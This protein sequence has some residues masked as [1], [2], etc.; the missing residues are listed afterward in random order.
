MAS[1]TD[2]RRGA[3]ISHNDN[4][5]LVLD[6]QHRTQGRQAGF[7]Q[8]T[9]RNLATGSSTNTKLRSGDSVD[10]LFTTRTSMEFSYIDG[11]DYHFL[12]PETFDDVVLDAKLLEEAKDFLEEGN[13]Y[14]ILFVENNPV[15]VQL[16]ASVEMEVAEAPDAIRGDTSSAPTKPVTLK[17]GLIVQTPLFVKTGD[18]IKISTENRSYLGR[19]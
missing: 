16:P 4:P 7:V 13:T 6:A 10:I 5:H 9:L 15:L 2:I 17:T 1:P 11:E 8:V 18:V 12:H 14:E 19:A 3:V